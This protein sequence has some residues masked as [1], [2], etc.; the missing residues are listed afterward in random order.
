M[1]I[2][3]AKVYGKAQG[4]WFRKWTQTKAHELGISGWVKNENNGRK[5]YK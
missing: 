4:V 3:K 5:I 1:R 2:L